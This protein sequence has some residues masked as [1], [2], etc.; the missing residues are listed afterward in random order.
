VT[1]VTGRPLARAGRISGAGITATLAFFLRE[2]PRARSAKG[3]GA[4]WPG[5]KPPR[6]LRLYNP[7]TR[8]SAPQRVTLSHLA[9]PQIPA[10]DPRGRKDPGAR[11]RIGR[12]IP[13]DVVLV[14]GPE[15][16][17][18]VIA[19]SSG[20]PSRATPFASSAFMKTRCASHSGCAS[21]AF[22]DRRAVRTGG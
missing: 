2:I 22:R 14:P 21:S 19:P 17:Q 7:E 18:H 9:N 8:G 20:P 4:I 16:E 5:L 10:C 13:L 6:L 15:Y 11:A 12:Q 1:R 3:S